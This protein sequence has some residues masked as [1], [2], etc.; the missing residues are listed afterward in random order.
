MAVTIPI[1]SI[2]NMIAV[3]PHKGAVTHHH[4]Q[5]I[6]PVNLSAIKRRPSAPKKPI[7]Y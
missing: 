1:R 3:P 4:D 2:A 6:T 5:R 7:K